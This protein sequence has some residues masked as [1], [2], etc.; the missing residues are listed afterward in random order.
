M[1]GQK[2]P[3]CNVD[4]YDPRTDSKK[5]LS[6]PKDLAGRFTLVLWYPADFSIVCPTEMADLL[7][8]RAEFEKV[9]LTILVAS[10]DTVY[11]HKG[12]IEAEDLLHGFDY[13]MLAD[14]SGAIARSLGIY[15]ETSGMARR[16]AIFVDPDGVIQ[17]DYQVANNIGR[18]AGEILRIAKA[19]KF[20]RDN[21][22]EACPASWDEGSST[23]PNN[24]KLAGRVGKSMAKA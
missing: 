4:A 23:V 6:F 8:R 10:T 11:T 1:I 22:G 17:A 18:S 2:F 15:D 5:R 12:W 3:E 14:H 16:A 13:T 24:V 7:K 9:G 21:P 20:V 19:L